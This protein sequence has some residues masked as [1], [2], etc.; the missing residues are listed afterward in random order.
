[1]EYD[2]I[3]ITTRR[4][5]IICEGKINRLEMIIA[6]MEKKY[7][8]GSDEFFREF[9]PSCYSPDREVTY[10]HES[11]LALVRW[12]ERLAAHQTNMTL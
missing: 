12:K 4:E 8:L 10:W 9:D 1:M 11:C 7:G 3:R 2:E 6:A 5:I